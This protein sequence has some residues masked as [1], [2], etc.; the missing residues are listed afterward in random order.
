[1]TLAAGAIVSPFPLPMVGLSLFPVG[2]LEFPISLLLF[3]VSPLAF[4]VG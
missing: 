1:M 4:P 2:S 3:P